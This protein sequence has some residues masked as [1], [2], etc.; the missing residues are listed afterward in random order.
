MFDYGIQRLPPV[1]GDRRYHLFDNQGELELVADFGS[2]WLP[3]EPGK[4]VR[5]ARSD[6]RL[7]ATL[8]FPDD[9]FRRKGKEVDKSYAIIFD[10]AVYAIIN[11][12]L[13]E[14]AEQLAASFSVEAGGNQWLL[15]PAGG[16]TNE[17]GLHRLPRGYGHYL[18][19]ASA[20]LPEPASVIRREA[21]NF[22]YT[23][24][25]EHDALAQPGLV[26]LA[27]VFLLD[28]QPHAT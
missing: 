24:T 19:P 22:D 3:N 12:L 2:P 21:A 5:F 25:V 27:L 7:V 1:A 6:G 16:Q 8:D 17:F 13:L 4:Q 10:Y 20:E 15:V 18:Q 26:I 28:G 23:A 11:E 14:S 9:V